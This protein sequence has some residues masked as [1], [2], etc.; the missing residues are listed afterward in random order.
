MYAVRR[1]IISSAARPISLSMVGRFSLSMN[2]PPI[3][4]CM[5]TNS[6]AM[7]QPVL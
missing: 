4:T 1:F 5:F 2:E 6:W 7:F 3:P